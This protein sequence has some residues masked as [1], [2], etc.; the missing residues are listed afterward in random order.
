MKEKILINPRDFMPVP[1]G[2][3]AFIKIDCPTLLGIY[4]Y[5]SYI[6]Q[7]INTTYY[8]DDE[9]IKILKKEVMYK[10]NISFRVV[11]KYFDDINKLE[12]INRALIS[13]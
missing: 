9:I 12:I 4:S 6:Y 3:N 8:I 5:I 2:I 11:N 13:L 10:F 1:V 7:H